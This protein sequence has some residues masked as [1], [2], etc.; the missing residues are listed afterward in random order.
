MT[1][2]TAQACPGRIRTL[3]LCFIVFAAGV[4]PAAAAPIVFSDGTFNLADYSQVLFQSGPA[5]ITPSQIAA[6]GNPG[7]A[8][9]ILYDVPNSSI[10]PFNSISGFRRPSFTYD[11]LTQG[12]LAS[13][14]ASVDK[15]FDIPDAVAVGVNTFRPL[16]FQGGNYY[17]AAVSV[18]PFVE[19]VY[20]SAGATG[21]VASDFNLF[22]FPTGPFNPAL[23]PDFS[24]GPMEF[25]FASGLTFNVQTG[26][27]RT[28]D[29]RHDNLR[30]Q[31]NAVPEP[32]SA[33]LV[34]SGLG[35]WAVARRGRNKRT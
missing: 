16:I 3:W 15:Y 12:A 32:A 11:P 23:H 34:L 33:L 13:I 29:F 17:L 35:A 18:L 1:G 26:A 5:T 25:G 22:A 8:L 4:V 10:V 21:L 19:G 28:A 6:G 7:F 20:V 14:D 2:R 24:G 31:L 27:N 9:Q 30:L